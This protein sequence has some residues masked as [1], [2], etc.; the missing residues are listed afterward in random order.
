METYLTIMVT[1]LVATQVIRITQNA[2]QLKRLNNRIGTSTDDE[3]IAMWDKLV[4]SINRL[5]EKIDK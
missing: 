2:I 4:E 1:V 3:V 5:S